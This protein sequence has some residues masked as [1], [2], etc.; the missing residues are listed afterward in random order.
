M[1]SLRSAN[2]PG[3]RRVFV[4]Q[5]LFIFAVVCFLANFA[6]YSE[7]AV[8]LDAAHASYALAMAGA[9]GGAGLLLA[10]TPL[11]KRFGDR[12]VSQ[13]GVALD[14]AAYALLAF[15]WSTWIFFIALA[16]WALGAAMAEPSL[17]TL[18]S[19]RAK[20]EERGAIMGLSDSINSV[21]MIA[22]PA[23]GAALVGSNGR[24]LGVLC[25]IASAIA[26][27]LGLKARA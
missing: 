14:L 10:V 22:G 19:K 23:A 12:I 5:F 11:A 17:T 2:A 15:A 7:R 21:A 1:A 6:L 26:L 4:R 3:V 18:L 8:R 24:M 9:V 27:A 20:Q 25:A 13:L 16:V